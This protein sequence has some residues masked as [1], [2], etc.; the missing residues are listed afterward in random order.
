MPQAP[1]SPAAKKK[2]IL[3]ETKLEE[4]FLKCLICGDIFN[5]TDRSP[6]LL[7]CHHT[8][9]LACLLEMFRVEIEQRQAMVSVYHNRLPSAVRIGCPTCRDSR[10][11]S[12]EELKKMPNDRTVLSLLDLVFHSESCVVNYCSRHQTQPL[13]F[14]C[15]TCIQPVCC[16]C[17]VLDHMQSDNHVVMNIEGALQKYKP[18]IEE[19][20]TKLANHASELMESKT[21]LEGAIHTLDTN[22]TEVINKLKETFQQFRT[23]ADDREEELA[24]ISLREIGRKKDDLTKCLELVQKRREQIKTTK[25]VLKRAQD[26]ENVEQVYTTHKK[27]KEILADQ[28]TIP[29][30]LQGEFSATL[31]FDDTEQTNVIFKLSEFGEVLFEHS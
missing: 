28:V 12:Q 27:L 20:L 22:R 10:I 31:D 4:M 13:N 8:F 14:F 15:E 30:K 21:I 17:T 1:K 19:C 16:D 9:C 23:A 3:D 7:P 26:D 29:D 5:N 24:E 25:D 2:L 18:M 11:I 6:K